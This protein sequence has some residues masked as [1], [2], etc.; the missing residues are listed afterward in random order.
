V[1]VSDGNR[2]AGMG[3][4]YTIYYL[5]MGLMPALAGVLFE[6]YG[7]RSPLIFA[8]VLMILSVCALSVLAIMGNQK[9]AEQPT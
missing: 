2:A 3:V 4:F 8:A 6:V 7:P 5:S 1:L 9:P